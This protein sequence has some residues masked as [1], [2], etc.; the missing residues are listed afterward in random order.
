[1]GGFIM[2]KFRNK[3][4][5][6]NYYD[7]RNIPSSTFTQNDATGNGNSTSLNASLSFGVGGRTINGGLANQTAILLGPN[8]FSES[9]AAQSATLLHENV[10]GYTG[11]SDD[12]IFG[13][14]AGYG[15]QQTG[16]GS[17]DISDWIQKDCP[18]K[19]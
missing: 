4:K 8:F 9:S 1:M 10:H 18:P 2:L 7:P 13:V 12:D 16:Q 3:A 19:Q 17:Q 6:T 14:F 11:W 15:L 5:D